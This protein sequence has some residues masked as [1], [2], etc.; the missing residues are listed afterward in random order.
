[1]VVVGRNITLSSPASDTG[2]LLLSETFQI[3][4]YENDRLLILKN[5]ITVGNQTRVLLRSPSIAGGKTTE[6]L[7]KMT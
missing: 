7:L 5:K 3:Q 6:L 2:A 4:N 1:M